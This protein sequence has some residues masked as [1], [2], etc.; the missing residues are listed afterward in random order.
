MSAQCNLFIAGYHHHLNHVKLETHRNEDGAN[1]EDTGSTDSHFRSSTKLRKSSLVRAPW[2][3]LKT[4][5]LQLKHKH[6][7]KHYAEFC[8]SG[9]IPTRMT[10]FS[11]MKISL[12][13]T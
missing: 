8:H 2:Y 10:P 1:Q 12:T 13:D 4:P 5:S 11:V 6:R 3:F 7:R 9:L